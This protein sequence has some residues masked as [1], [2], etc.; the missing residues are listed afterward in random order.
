MRDRIF[1]ISDKVISG[2]N[3]SYEEKEFLFK[4]SDEF[5]LDLISA[6]YRIR[7]KFRGNKFST[8]SI[9]SA[10]T[11]LCSEDCAFCAQ[12]IRS[13]AKIQRHPLLSPNE[14]LD[15][16]LDAEECGAK[17]FSIVTSGKG[18]VGREKEFERILESIK[19]IISNTKLKV[20]V[21]LG[22]LRKEAIKKLAEAGVERIHHNIETSRSYFKKICTT[23]DFD[24]KLETIRSIK[25][26]GLEVCSGFIIGMGERVEDRIEM[27]DILNSLNVDSV[28]INILI[29]IKGTPLESLQPMKPKEAL[30]S[31][32]AF[33]FLMP[34]KELRLCG[35]RVQNLRDLQALSLYVVDGMLIGREALT[36]SIRDPELDVQMI[37]DMGFEIVR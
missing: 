27:A 29:P 34:D 14:I 28:P 5:L 4:V 33:R 19:L 32:A 30:K 23:H 37:K 13:K 8:C 12:S 15:A 1:E 9:I 35:G 31:V 25:E 17:R 22:A 16:A 11:G 26:F 3:L 36:T 10:K 20:G 18:Y 7:L 6:A 24:S 21:S 2:E